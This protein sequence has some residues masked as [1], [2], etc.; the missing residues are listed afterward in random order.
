MADHVPYVAED[1]CIACGAC[2]EICPEVFTVNESLGF[3]QVMNPSGAPAEKI[4]EAVDAAS[5][6]GSLVLVSNAPNNGACTVMPVSTVMAFC[7]LL[8]ESPRMP[9]GESVTVRITAGSSSRS[10]AP[11]R[12]SRRTGRE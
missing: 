9:S 1:E 7:T 3:A 11:S 2:E 8:A 4:Q 5:V 10:S 6:P 12:A